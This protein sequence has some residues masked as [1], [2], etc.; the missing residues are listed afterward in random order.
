MG[1]HK[2][3][4]VHDKALKLYEINGIIQGKLKKRKKSG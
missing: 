4:G 2:I 1:L 3:M